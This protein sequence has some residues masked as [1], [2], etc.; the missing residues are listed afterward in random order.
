MDDRH[1]DDEPRAPAGLL[2]AHGVVDVLE[3]GGAVALVESAEGQELLASHD[4]ARGRRVV[5]VTREGVGPVTRHD[6]GPAD[7]CS[8]PVV[9]HELTGLLQG[10]VRVDEQRR[11]DADHRIVEC[12]NQWLEPAGPDDHIGIEEAEEL[13]GRVLRPEVVAT[14]ESE[15]LVG[16]DQ[17]DRGDRPQQFSSS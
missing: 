13:P 2:D 4:P 11:S 14:G 9:V 3:V 10:A 12:R 1:V 8:A 6:F 15:V 7:R 17:V 16:F 5:D